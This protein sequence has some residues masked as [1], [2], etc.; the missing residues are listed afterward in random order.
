MTEL[1]WL[2]AQI[3]LL[4]RGPQDLPAS[5]LLLAGTV[6]GYV[7][8]NALLSSVLPP[9][10]GSWPMHLAFDVLFTLAWYQIL[11][12]LTGRPERF[13]QTATA[14]F[15]Y[16]LVLTPLWMS[17]AWLVQRYGGH[18]VWQGPV[19]LLAMAIV[20]WY[21]AANGR[22]VKAALEWS[23]SPSVALV[24]L[25]LLVEQLIAFQIFPRPSS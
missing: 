13:L 4:R 6:L 5:T 24:I 16:Q 19:A 23:T 1:L 2:Y 12:R 7:A 21:I 14:V 17:T 3:A 8:V 25:Q 20:I 9:A 15:G 22:I 18:E 11:L 10:P